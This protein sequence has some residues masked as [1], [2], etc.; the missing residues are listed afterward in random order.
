MLHSEPGGQAVKRVLVTGVDGFTGR[1]LAAALREEG[2][3]VHGIVRKAR[4]AAEPHLHEADLA[5]RARLRA[6]LKFVQPHYVVHLAAIAFVAH[7]DVDDLYKTN[8]LGTRN[9]LEAMVKSDVQFT[10][11]LIASSANVYG[12][13]ASGFLDES[14]PPAPSNDY[15]VSKLAMEHLARIYS[16]KLPIVIT[17]PFNY[18]GVGQS[19]NFLIPKIVS[20]VRRR[21]KVLEL[22]NLDVARDF[23]DVRSVVQYYTKL[24]DCPAAVGETFNVCSGAAYTLKEVLGLLLEKAKVS[25]EVKVNP[26]FVRANEVKTLFGSNK[27]IVSVVG[28]VPE[29]TLS[30]TLSWMLEANGN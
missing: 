29:I 21:A 11:A 24:L 16:E 3:E 22:G 12:N 17:R 15:G 1:Y 18:T 10:S 2:Y 5:D 6:I 20:H 8:L 23:S 13:A 27:K 30:E 14:T 28:K 4:L 9:L 25:I 7:G 26:A 19:E